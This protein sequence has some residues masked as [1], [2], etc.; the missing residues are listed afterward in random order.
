MTDDE[1]EDTYSEWKRKMADGGKRKRT[2]TKACRPGGL[3][4]KIKKGPIEPNVPEKSS[5][6]EDRCACPF[7]ATYTEFLPPSIISKGIK[8][9]LWLILFV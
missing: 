4:A 9:A 6:S 7:R 3:G 5:R 1:D 2:L 8:W